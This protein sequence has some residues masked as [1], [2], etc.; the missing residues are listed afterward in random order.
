MMMQA[1]RVHDYGSDVLTLE[2]VAQPEP[3]PNK[4]LIIYLYFSPRD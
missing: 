1:I 3:Q 4:V 2:T